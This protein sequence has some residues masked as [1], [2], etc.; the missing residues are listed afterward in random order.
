[1]LVRKENKVVC[2]EEKNW[3]DPKSWHYISKYPVFSKEGSGGVAF[4]DGL[5]EKKLELLN[6]A[7]LCID[8]AM[9]NLKNANSVYD[10]RDFKYLLSHADELT[11]CWNA[12]KR[13]GNW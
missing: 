3:D 10:L 2:K 6:N 1:M 4:A 7:I 12:L 13:N 9:E 8:R 11:K 5:G